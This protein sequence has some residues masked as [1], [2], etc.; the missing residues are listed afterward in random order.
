MNRLHEA[1]GK[2]WKAETMKIPKKDIVELYKI[3]C[4]KLKECESTVSNFSDWVKN[5]LEED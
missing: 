4:M 2:E 5:N 3:V 1:Y